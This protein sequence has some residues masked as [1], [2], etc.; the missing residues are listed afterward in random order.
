M[1]PLDALLSEDPNTILV[2]SDWLEDQGKTILPMVMKL[3][4][5][6]KI[7]VEQSDVR[8]NFTPWWE[9]YSTKGQ[10]FMEIHRW[11]LQWWRSY[12][13][14]KEKCWEDL[15]KKTEQ[16]EQKLKEKYQEVS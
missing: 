15:I 16:E 3:L 2:C 5:E 8:G 6:G 11:L 1:D 9:D 13:L 14:T 7:V 12:Y 4:A 10:P